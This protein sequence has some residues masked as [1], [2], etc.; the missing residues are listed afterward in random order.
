MPT[1]KRKRE[2][3]LTEPTASSSTTFKPEDFVRG[4]HQ[5]VASIKDV[6]GKGKAR[7]P[8]LGEEGVSGY[9]AE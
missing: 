6:K 2:H 9:K 7:D 5:P 1:K 3:A 8:L 4:F